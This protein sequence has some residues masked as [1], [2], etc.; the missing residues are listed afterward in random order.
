M[1]DKGIKFKDI[2]KNCKFK[3]YQ[4]A[5][6]VNEKSRFFRL[7]GSCQE[8]NCPLLEDDTDNNPKG[9]IELIS[10]VTIPKPKIN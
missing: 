2:E 3:T 7:V 5:K 6:C 8:V 1:K 10:K 9:C 4:D